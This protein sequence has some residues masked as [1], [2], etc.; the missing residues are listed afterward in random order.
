MDTLSNSFSTRPSVLESKQ[1]KH[2]KGEGGTSDRI[3]AVSRKAFW[4]MVSDVNMKQNKGVEVMTAKMMKWGFLRGI[5]KALLSTFKN[6]SFSSIAIWVF[7][8]CLFR[9]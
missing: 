6:P 1:P 9:L 4:K 2:C 3:L 5:V 7:S 8:I